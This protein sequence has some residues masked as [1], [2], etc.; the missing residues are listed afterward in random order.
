MELVQEKGKRYVSKT[1]PDSKYHLRDRS[2]VE[3]PV[4]VVRRLCEE[5]PD[6]PRKDVLT[7]CIEAGVNKNTA[8]TQYSLWRAKQ[9]NCPPRG[10]PGLVAVDA[11]GNE[12]GDWED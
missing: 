4:A 8:M 9:R 11:D 5:N 7:L 12:V 6:L 2:D 1:A 10:I 3:K